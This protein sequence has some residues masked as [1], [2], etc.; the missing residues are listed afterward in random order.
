M[1]HTVFVEIAIILLL[2]VVVA[3][4]GA[5][6]RQPL[7]IAFIACGILIGP[8]VLGW[9]SSGDQIDLLADMG[10]ALLLFVVGLKLDL[11][12]IRTMGRVALATGMGQVAFTAVFGF[13]IALE[14]GRAHV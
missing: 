5:R 2:A 8:S 1:F 3:A 7:I 12:T 10:I 13:A 6:L 9:M 14:I 4:V 11:H